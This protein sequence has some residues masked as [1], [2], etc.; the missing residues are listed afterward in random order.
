MSKH[1]S[2][3]DIVADIL[4]IVRRE[5]K[6]THIMYR[7]NLSYAL[8]CKYLDKLITTRLIRYNE[9]DTVF[10]LTERGVVYLNR[11]AEYENL[12]SQ[13]EANKSTLVKKEAILTEIL[14][15]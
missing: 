8:L 1:R 2:Q 6:K 12:R 15:I 7:A 14:N 10:E 3:E 13:L 4:L 11:Y 9:D 5:P